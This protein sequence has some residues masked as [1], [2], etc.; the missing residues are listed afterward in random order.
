MRYERIKVIFYQMQKRCAIAL[1]DRI[2]QRLA[3]TVQLAT[4]QEVS[5]LEFR[6]SLECSQKA[7]FTF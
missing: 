5:V 1:K 6:F 2:L 4:S 3:P 7:L